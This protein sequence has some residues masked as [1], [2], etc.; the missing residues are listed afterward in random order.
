MDPRYMKFFAAF[1]AIMFF[2]YS[3][4]SFMYKEND[5]SNSKPILETGIKGLMY[6]IGS[7]LM[8]GVTFFS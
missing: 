4:V 1:L 3:I 7:V 5:P 2:M 8:V 6:L